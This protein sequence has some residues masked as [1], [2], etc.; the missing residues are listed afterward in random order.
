MPL[1]TTSVLQGIYRIFK[2]PTIFCTS[3]TCSIYQYPYYWYIFS[4][5]WR[6]YPYKMPGPSHHGS[7][8]GDCFHDVWAQFVRAGQSVRYGTLLQMDL[9]NPYHLNPL[10]LYYIVNRKGAQVLQS[11]VSNLPDLQSS[12][13]STKQPFLINWPKLAKDRTESHWS[14][15][16]AF[17]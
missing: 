2:V 5:L 17:L 16:E 12:S 8:D 1:D 3:M 13:K 10:M 15:R 6:Q 11:N 9:T 14:C 7:S 4:I